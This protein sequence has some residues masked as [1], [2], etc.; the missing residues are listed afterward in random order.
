MRTIHI[1]KAETIGGIQYYRPLERTDELLMQHLMNDDYIE[2]S[3]SSLEKA[4][5]VAEAHGWKLEI[6]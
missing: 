1:T 5:T 6:V 3:E 4:T 2:I